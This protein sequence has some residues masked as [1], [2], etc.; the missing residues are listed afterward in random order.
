MFKWQEKNREICEQVAGKQQ[1]EVGTGGREIKET[2][3]RWQVMNKKNC[4]Q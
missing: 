4:V 2:V 1:G 3:N